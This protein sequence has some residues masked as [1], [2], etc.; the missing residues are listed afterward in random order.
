MVAGVAAA[1]GLVTRH[2]S[3]SE[4]DN[5]RYLFASSLAAVARSDQDFG[6]LLSDGDWEK[7]TPDT[8][9]WV[10]TDDYSNI[11]GALLRHMK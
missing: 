9:Q 7:I 4:Y 11:V 5:E 8:D 3:W 1:N 2:F 6:A 10:W